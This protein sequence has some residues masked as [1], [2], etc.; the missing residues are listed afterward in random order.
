[1]SHCSGGSGI[2][3]VNAPMP[4]GRCVTAEHDML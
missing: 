1:M 3:I 4:F 2:L